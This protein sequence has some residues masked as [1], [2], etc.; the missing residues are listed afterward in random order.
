LSLDAVVDIPVGFAMS[1]GQDARAVH[2]SSLV[3]LEACVQ[4]VNRQNSTT[5]LF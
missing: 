3:M 5:V 4:G 2:R 1:N